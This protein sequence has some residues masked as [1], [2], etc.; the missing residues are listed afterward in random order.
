MNDQKQIFKWLRRSLRIIPLADIVEYYYLIKEEEHR[1]IKLRIKQIG[2]RYVFARTG[3]EDYLTLYS[4]FYDQFHLPPIKL[5]DNPIIL[6]LGSNIGCTILHYHH[7]YP[8]SR[9]IGVEMDQANYDLCQINVAE[10]R[11]VDLMHTAISHN[12]RIVSYNKEAK[13]DAYCISTSD[14]GE[15]SSVNSTTIKAIIAKFNLPAIDFVKMD[16]EGEEVQL[17]DFDRDLGWLN[18]VKSLNIEVHGNANVLQ[19][20]LSVL[21]K[22]GFRAWKDAHHWSAIMATRA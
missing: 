1:L 12:E 17:F 5:A 2:N 20:I 21:G 8:D 3:T 14:T 22:C 7:L 19:N 13:E 16:I 11:N 10:A 9:I 15:M 18:N 6:D 4:T